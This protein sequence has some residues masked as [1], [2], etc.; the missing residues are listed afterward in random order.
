MTPQQRPADPMRT[1]VTVTTAKIREIGEDDKWHTL[2]ECMDTPN[3]LRAELEKPEYSGHSVWIQDC[4]GSRTYYGLVKTCPEAM[5]R[6]QLEAE[7]AEMRQENPNEMSRERLGRMN[8]L[9][10]ALDEMNAQE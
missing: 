4:F 5:T 6:E 3:A 10:S 2:G 9:M 1:Y 7:L 8:S